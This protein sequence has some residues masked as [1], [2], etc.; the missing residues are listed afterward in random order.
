MSE[1]CIK[2]VMDFIKDAGYAGVN[3]SNEYKFEDFKKEVSSLLNTGH[4]VKDMYGERFEIQ[5]RTMKIKKIIGTCLEVIL[6]SQESQIIL[7]H[8]C[9]GYILTHKI[10]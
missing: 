7:T 8:V 5:G 6:T 1:I 4:Y 9:K 3:S 10:L 2:D